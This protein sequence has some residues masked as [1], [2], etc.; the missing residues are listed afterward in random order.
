MKRFS[1]VGVIMLLAMT[2]FS[3]CGA[4][5][6]SASVSKTDA[7]NPVVVYKATHT[8]TLHRN[9]I[10]VRETCVGAVGITKSQAF[11][12]YIQGRA[13]VE[14][15]SPY[16]GVTC[17]QTADM[18]MENTHTGAWDADG[19]GQT[20]HGCAGEVDSSIRTNSCSAT[21]ILLAYRT[22]GIFVVVDSHGDPLAWHG[23]SGVLN[24][25]RIC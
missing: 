18:Q 6:A 8:F 16:P 11:P 23:P 3:F 2:L 20:R 12:G 7:N 17:A 15:C 13:W 4:A 22:M 5:A 9:G 21:S 14:R 10:T 19:D 24:V 1:R 25:T